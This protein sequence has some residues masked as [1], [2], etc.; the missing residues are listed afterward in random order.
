MSVARGSLLSM[1][2]G[3]L[4]IANYPYSGLVQPAASDKSVFVKFLLFDVRSSELIQGTPVEI[5]M[6]LQKRWG[7]ILVSPA[8]A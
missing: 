5:E 2:P 7:G 8:N 4:T 3:V 6:L 1:M